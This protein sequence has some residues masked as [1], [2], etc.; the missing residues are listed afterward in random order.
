ME[1]Y[2]IELEFGEE[3]EGGFNFVVES[4]NDVFWLIGIC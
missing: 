2:L 3:W 4:S 1:E